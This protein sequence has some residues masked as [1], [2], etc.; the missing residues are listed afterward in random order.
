MVEQ[1]LHHLDCLVDVIALKVRI[2]AEQASVA[3]ALTLHRGAVRQPVAQAQL[4]VQRPVEIA[5]QQVE[6]SLVVVVQHGLDE[7]PVQLHTIA[8]PAAGQVA[9]LLRLVGDAFKVAAFFRFSGG[10]LAKG[11]LQVGR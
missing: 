4:V 8:Q 7:Q 5:R 11:P 1:G 3:K 2:E 9:P 10:Q 6:G